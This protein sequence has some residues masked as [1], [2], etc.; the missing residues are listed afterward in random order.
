MRV[1]ILNDAVR[2]AIERLKVFAPVNGEYY[3]CFSGGK[4]SVV[5]KE[6]A[7]LGEIPVIWHYNLTTID[8]PELVRFIQKEH[9]DVKWVQPKKGPFFH[10]VAVRGMPTRIARWCCHE[11]KESRVPR[12]MRTI[13]GVRWAESTRR[14]NL[15]GVSTVT[16]N[17]GVVVIAPIVD[18]SDHLVWKFIKS[19]NL[20]YCSLYDEGFK[21]LGCVGCPMT[22]RNG[23]IL[24]FKRWP[25]YEELWK[26]ACRRLFEN[27][28][29]Q[30]RFE[31]WSSWE[32][33]WNWWMEAPVNSTCQGSLDFYS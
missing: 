13:M 5:I 7:R 11:F 16:K 21:R 20:P 14:K 2:I 23:R 1:N 12:G 3:G 24:Q 17:S 4:D 32:E 10:R 30:G 28:K 9:P 6:I 33:V 31:K 26:K 25:R 29:S 15:W 19:R 22:M 18:W 27:R 8:P